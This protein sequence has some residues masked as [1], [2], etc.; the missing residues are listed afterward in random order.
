MTGGCSPS[1]ADTPRSDV[2]G[3]ATTRA[4]SLA[5]Q[6]PVHKCRYV[7]VEC[8]GSHLG[9]RDESLLTPNL[10]GKDGRSQTL[11]I[12]SLLRARTLERRKQ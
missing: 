6:L 3:W 12:V 4:P 10:L 7:R 11:P 1:Q 8:G 5:A 9:E 2:A